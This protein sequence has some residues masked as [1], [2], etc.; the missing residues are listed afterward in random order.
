MLDVSSDSSGDALDRIIRRDVAKA[1]RGAVLLYIANT[2]IVILFDLAI[3]LVGS[4]LLFFF[5]VSGF[6]WIGD[7]AAAGLSLYAMVAFLW[8]RHSQG[9]GLGLYFYILGL[10]GLSIG[11][12]F[13][14]WGALQ[15]LSSGYW[16]RQYHKTGEARSARDGGEVVVY[17]NDSLVNVK[18][19]KLVRIGW[20]LPRS[21]IIGGLVALAAGFVLLNLGSLL[22]LSI[23]PVSMA[24]IGWILFIDGLSFITVL[25]AQ[26]M[27]L[28]GY[29]RL[30]PSEDQAKA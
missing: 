17:G 14:A 27:G 10:L 12:I 19:S 21:W 5:R 3:F 23:G 4:P 20:D 1:A 6:S 9:S 16:L 24:R 2:V 8:A 28:K 18:S 25:I 29:V 11:A 13:F 26:S 22:Q 30:P 7:G 15:F